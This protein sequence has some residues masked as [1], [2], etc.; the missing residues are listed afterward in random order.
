MA[1]DPGRLTTDLIGD[2]GSYLSTRFHLRHEGLR[3]QFS[4][5]LATDRRLHSGPFLELMPPFRPGA[6]VK[7]LVEQGVL[8]RALLD[9]TAEELHLDR[10]LYSH[11][12]RAI[13]KVQRGRNVVVATGTGS[14]KT[15]SYV[16]P[17]VSHLLAV[18][19]AERQVPA[20]VRAL[21]VYPM[22]AL[23]NDQLRR[24]RQLLSGSPNLTFGRYTG[25]TPKERGKGLQRFREMWPKEKVIPNEL[26]SREEMWAS[27]PDI[28]MTNFAML[29]YLLV[30]PQDSVFFDE[31]VAEHLRFIVFDEVHTYDGAKGT[32]IAMLLRRLK[33]RVGIRERG[34]VTCIA[35]SATLGGGHD[36]PDVASFATDLFDERFEWTTDPERRDVVEADRVPYTRPAD[37]WPRKTPFFADLAAV[38][39]RPAQE[40]LVAFREVVSRA[41]IPDHARTVALAELE[42]VD[43]AGS[44]RPTETEWDWGSETQAAE[45]AEEISSSRWARALWHLLRGDSRVVA[46]NE[47]CTSKARSLSDVEAEV[48]AGDSVPSADRRRMLLA[49]V[50]LT[51]MARE[52]ENSLPL[53]RA[54]YHFFLRALEGGFVC[55]GDH[56]GGGPRL[57]LERRTTCPEHPGHRTFELGVCRRCGE[58]FLV[59]SLA[60]DPETHRH[61]VGSEDPTEDAIDDDPSEGRGRLFLALTPGAADAADDD[62]I[63]ED[64][65]KGEEFVAVTVC[66]RCGVLGDRGAEGFCGCEGKALPR[67]VLRVKT[68]GAGAVACPSCSARSRQREVVQTLYTGTD[69]PVA[70]IATTVFQSA[71]TDY[72]RG[73]GEKKKLLTFSDSRQDAAFFAPYLETLYKAA[74]RRHVLL[75]LIEG[76]DG[77]LAVNDL[78]SRLEHRIDKE[79][80]LGEQATSDSK[81]QEAWRWVM[82]ELLHTTKDR[83]SLEELGLVSFS[84]RRFKDVPPPP[85]LLKAPW[86]LTPDEA[87]LM[88]EVLLNSLREH[89]VVSLP[90]GLKGDDAVFLPG[91]GDAY[92]ALKRASGDTI[93]RSWVPQVSHLSNTRLDFLWRFAKKRGIQISELGLK[94]FLEQLFERYL[95]APSGTFV[96]KYLDRYSNDTRRGV[97]FQLAT[98]GWQVT[99]GHLAGS[100][101]EC[102]RCGVRRFGSLSGVCPTYRCDGEL[103]NEAGPG[104][105]RADHYRRRYREIGA[106]WMIAREHTAQLDSETASGYQ[107]L[108]YTGGIDVLSCSTTFELGVD[109]GELETI[110]LRNV[111]PTPANYAQRAGRAGRRSGAAAFVVTYAQRRSH[112]LTYFNDP[113]RMIAGRVRPPAFRLDNERIVRRHLYATAWSA[114]FAAHPSAF[115]N[116]QIKHLFGADAGSGSQVAVL[117]DFFRARPERLRD[118]LRRVIPATLQ[119]SLGVGEWRWADDLL[120]RA[121]MS[122]SRLVLDYERECGHYIQAERE[123]SE[124]GNHKR[125]SLY[126]W[127]R[128]TVQMRHLLGV[129]ANHGLFP[130]YGFPVDVVGLEIQRDALKA[131]ERKGA[132]NQLDD[133]GLELQRDLKLAISEYAPGSEVVA[134]GYVWRSAGVKVYPDRR[135]PEVP[136]YACPCGAFQLVAAGDEPDSCPHCG[137]SHKSARAGRFVKPEFGFVTSS[138]VPKRSTTRRPARQFASRLAFAEFMGARPL[139]YV[140][141]W[142]GI[143]VGEPRPARLVSINSGKFRR[144][145]RICQSCGF[146]EPVPF[147]AAAI[148][149][150][151]KSPRGT[152]CRGDIT[153]SVDLGH[154]FITDVLELRLTSAKAMKKAGWWTVAYAVAEG[155][156]SALGIKREDLDVTV[157]IALDGGYSVFLIDSVP[158]G[159]GHVMRIHEHLPLVLRRALERVSGC[160]CEETTSCYECLRTFSNQR[161]HSQLVRGVARDFIAMALKRAGATPAAPSAGDALS[162]VLDEELQ[163]AVRAMVLRGIPVPEVG[164]EFV[165]DVGRVSGELELAWPE[166]SV[167][168]TGPTGTGPDGWTVLSTAEAIANPGVLE[169][170][171]RLAPQC[172]AA[173]ITPP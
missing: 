110:L 126:Q 62:E 120:T 34:R 28:L 124:T 119:A 20:K 91:R 164:Y 19:S 113:I 77:P 25:E 172:S 115:G 68:K 41:E 87:W 106:L 135:L 39:E 94:T 59:G 173:M 49:L 82:A 146:A 35:T 107:N 40:R 47:A 43:G 70:E 117:E 29:E 42:S 109:L 5:L 90:A 158:G 73:Q 24:I 128:R 83:R 108:F 144:G 67:D 57:F 17:I 111:P 154:D 92:V 48:F 3:R 116:G 36:F 16:L 140:E 149:R 8:D 155:A 78:A 84:L 142:P 30:R 1:L 60:T 143:R 45:T 171:L 96:Q 89:H 13:E 156:A 9:V 157:R 166:S 26:K 129:L 46:L 101:Y 161:M 162:L 136:Y 51:S 54:R 23:A 141:R 11:Q 85:P 12:Q 153:F 6:S 69:E 137:E 151:H 163:E 64:T 130:K 79:T 170:A 118:S 32:E 147:G 74:L 44:G 159:A 99:A 61:F 169:A 98:R 52:D 145:F 88:V 122:V 81:S 55:L 76:V 38:M 133:F 33:D 2:Y 58:S 103:K 66:V 72:M 123:A 7:E 112:D 167:G 168:V 75:E 18:K 148:P 71:N 104:A 65:A 93:T 138:D 114:F 86:N 134:A 150:E 50:T 53:V 4:E 31:G 63:D 56:S 14:G 152:A 100:V 132:G 27:P 165:D 127:I 22:N 10:P 15:E 105:S 125:A 102:D 97:V 121:T 139:E 160:R 21:L 80:W 95:A 131:I 37:V